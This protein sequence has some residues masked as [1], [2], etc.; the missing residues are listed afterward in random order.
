MIQRCGAGL[1]TEAVQDGSVASNIARQ[2]L[3][4]NR[5]SLSI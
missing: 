5:R 3:E 4:S 2:E 1:A